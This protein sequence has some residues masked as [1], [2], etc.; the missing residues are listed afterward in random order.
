M[1]ETDKNVIIVPFYEDNYQSLSI[2]A[3]NF[4]KKRKISISTQNI[5]YI[6]ERAKGNRLNLKNE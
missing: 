5:N 1:F 3:Q 2:I 4:F 6:V